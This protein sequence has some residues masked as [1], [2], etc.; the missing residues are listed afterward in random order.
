MQI[1][2]YRKHQIC[3]ERDGQGWRA[4]IRTPNSAQWT[5][6]A[7]SRSLTGGKEVLSQAKAIVDGLCAAGG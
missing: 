1:E 7:Q 4:M 6:G 3:I 5:L 2:T